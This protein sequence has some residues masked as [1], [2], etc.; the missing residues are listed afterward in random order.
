MWQEENVEFKAITEVLGIKCNTDEETFQ[1]NSK[2]IN[3]NFLKPAANRQLLKSV[4]RFYDSLGLFAPTIVVGKII[5]QDAWL[6]GVQ[7]EEI[8]PPNIAKQWKKW[9]SELPSLND[10]CIPRWIGLS[11]SSDC[12]LHIFCDSSERAFGAVL[13]IRFQEGKTTKVQLLS[14]GNR[15]SPLK[16]ITL[17]KIS[18]PSPPR[19]RRSTNS[20]DRNRSR[21]E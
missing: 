11:P 4:A 21:L 5:F 17:Q 1:I 6:S 2:G 14:R 7:W 18:W 9:I 16:R 19:R 8:L 3:Q 12:F 10:I 20:I 15:L 13:Y